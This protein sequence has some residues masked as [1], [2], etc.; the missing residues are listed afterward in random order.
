MLLEGEGADARARAGARRRAAAGRPGGAAPSQPVLRRRRAPARR[1][2][3]GRPVPCRR[4]RPV[5]R[6]ARRPRPR[7]RR[8]GRRRHDRERARRTEPRTPPA[9]RRR[10]R[11]E[12]A[13]A[14]ARAAR[15][16]A[17]GGD[18]PATAWRAW[19]SR[20][21]TRSTPA[22]GRSRWQPPGE[23]VVRT[24]S[25]AA[26]A[27]TVSP[28]SRR[29]ASAA[30][31]TSTRVADYPADRGD[32]GPWRRVLPAGR[33]PRRR[34]GRA[35]AAA[36]RRARRRWSPPPRCDAGAAGWSSCT[37]THAQV[38]SSRRRRSCGC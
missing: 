23:D 34:P 31:T 18:R 33:R 19:P 5:R 10:P 21:P 6:Q 14:G 9:A 22:A 11:R 24:R 4:R 15:R 2:A 16:R 13:R 12:P 26:A 32:H 27:R 35:R 30:A 29:C 38:R 8:G 37:R 20:S 36:A 1:P 7:L 28:A 17:G 25:R 3:P